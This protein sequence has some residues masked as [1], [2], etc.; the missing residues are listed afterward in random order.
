MN[1]SELIA[2][3]IS[4]GLLPGSLNE[5][6]ELFA[7]AILDLGLQGKVNFDDQNAQISS[8]YQTR[9][10]ALLQ[11]N[12]GGATSDVSM[13]IAR[14]KPEPRHVDTTPAIDEGDGGFLITPEVE[15]AIIDEAQLFAAKIC[16]IYRTNVVKAARAGI[17]DVN[18][19]IM[20][21]LGGGG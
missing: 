11:R 18:A 1:V 10:R 2:N 5:S 21:S 3:L 9:I 12:N 4:Q 14:S 17:A 8:D 13:A 7:K 16:K 20:E 19:T 15:L 6:R